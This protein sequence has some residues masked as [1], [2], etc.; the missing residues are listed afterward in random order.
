MSPIDKLN[1]DLRARFPDFQIETRKA[2]DPKGFQ[3]LTMRCGRF[4]IA[5][6]WK[7]DRGF[8]VSSFIDDAELEDLFS[9]PDEWYSNVDAVFHRIVSLVL[10]RKCTKPR[11]ATIPEIRHR[12]KLSQDALSK[13]LQMRQATYSKLERRGDVLVSSLRKVIEAMGGKLQI[14]VVFQDTQDAQE[15]SL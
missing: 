6:E 4:E 2:D 10:D 15:I 1:L 12:R 13:T 3:F 5:V 8:G 7:H 9:P 14:Q 11:S